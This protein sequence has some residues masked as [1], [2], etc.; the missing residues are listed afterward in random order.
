MVEPLRTN[1]LTRGLKAL[2]LWCLPIVALIAGASWTSGRPWL[3]IPAFLV[4]GVACVANAARC[5]R[6]HCYVTG[7]L[8]LLAA[9]YVVLAEVQVVPMYPTILLDVVLIMT[10]LA[11]L[12]E[13]PLGRY[14]RKA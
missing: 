14:R 6:L 7:P 3:W 4:M 10:G 11:Y 2:F 12:A 13:V 5:G 8:F 1:D 9:V